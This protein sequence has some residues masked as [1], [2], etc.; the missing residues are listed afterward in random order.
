MLMYVMPQQYLVAVLYSRYK[1]LG[2]LSSLA[3]GALFNITDA[4]TYGH[5]SCTVYLQY[6][7]GI[8]TVCNR[9]S[10]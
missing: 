4:A 1:T 3:A 8:Y 2:K 7:T 5:S 6:C 10:V 9:V